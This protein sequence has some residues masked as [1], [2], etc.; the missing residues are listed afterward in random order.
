M[1]TAL[2]ENLNKVQGLDAG[3]DDYV[4][5]P[6]SA[7]ELLARIRAVLRRA[8]LPS[9]YQSVSG[10]EMAGLR[11]DFVQ[12]RVFVDD[13]EVHLSPIE[14]RLLRTLVQQVGRILTPAYLL[15]AVWG[16][17]YEG[18][19]HLVWQAIHRLRR[20]IEP[21]PRQPHYLHTRPGIGY[22]FDPQGQ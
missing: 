7:D 10:F 6:F 21:D 5:K 20:K 15:E 22:L 9:Q 3:A 12:Q 18:D 16:E 19:D 11:V 4:T 1:V 13:R 14:Y 8:A 17:S 2:A